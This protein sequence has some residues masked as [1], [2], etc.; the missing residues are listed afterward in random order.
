MNTVLTGAL[1]MVCNTAMS[2]DQAL[3]EALGGPARVAELLGYRK[4]GTQRVQNWLTRGIP[5]KVKLER[6][7]LFQRKRRKPKAQAEAAEA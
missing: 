6:P 5:A 2:T 3:I 7:D 4:W 1:N